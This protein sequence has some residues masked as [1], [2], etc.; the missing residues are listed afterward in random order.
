MHRA[1]IS[2]SLKEGGFAVFDLSPHKIAVCHLIQLFAPPAQQTV[3]FP[4]ESVS[5]HNRLG[6]FLFSLTRACNDFVEPPLIDLLSQL[7]AF[8]DPVNGWLCDHLM[9]SLSEISSPDDLFT[10]FEKLRGVIS[11]PD[12]GVCHLLTN[13]STYCNSTDPSYELPEDD[14]LGEPE[15]REFLEGSE[16]Y[17]RTDAFQKYR[18]TI[19]G[20]SAGENSSSLNTATGLISCQTNDINNR[21]CEDRQGF[22]RTRWQVE[23]Y[24]NM[25]ADLLENLFHGDYLVALENLH[26]YFDYSAGNE[27]LFNRSSASP[28]DVYVGR[29]ETALLCLGTMH[30]YFGHPKK[31][32]EALTE[33]LRLSQLSNDDACLAYTLA[34]I[35]NLLSDAGIANT[36]GMLGSQDSL[37]NSVVHLGT[38]PLRLQFPEPAKDN[39]LQKSVCYGQPNPIPGSVSQLSGS[40]YLLRATS[41]ELYGSAPLVRLN[42]LV[43]AICFANSASSM[44][45]SL[46]YVKL[47]QHLAVYKGYNEAFAA[48][49]LA[50][51]KFSPVSKSRIQLLKPQLLHE[52]ALHRAKMKLH[53]LRPCKTSQAARD[54]GYLHLQK[55]QQAGNP[56]SAGPDIVILHTVPQ[57]LPTHEPQPWK[58]P[59]NHMHVSCLARLYMYRF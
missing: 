15:L 7:R 18:H 13:I 17:N 46:A 19:G 48:L 25:Q 21:R 55:Q 11:N 32:L 10:F 6:L 29:Y 20:I 5:Q 23:G 37:E 36:S 44:D 54:P 22:L 35:C 12:G 56:L 52:R 8:G 58:L 40:S 1:S 49:K 24:L 38:W 43:Y 42:A 27:G 31:A 3:P 33:A 34:A 4:F 26:C 51:K 14:E 45:L 2:G 53:N 47:I 16:P 28:P 50:E 57:R 59:Q 39:V 9:S 30:S 41:W